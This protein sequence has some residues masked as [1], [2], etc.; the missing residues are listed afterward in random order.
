[1][2]TF[3]HVTRAE[4]LPAILREGLKPAIGRRSREADEPRPAVYIFPSEKA[5]SD[6]L[7]TWLGEEFEPEADLLMLEV[8]LKP[9]QVCY[10]K[11]PHEA[12]CYEPV[13]PDRIRAQ[14]PVAPRRPLPE[15]TGHG[16]QDDHVAPARA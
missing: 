4:K 9:E 13:P 6:A 11:G 1:M 12:L 16:S 14:R 15:A 8:A 5:A 3:F 2:Q 10:P 7:A